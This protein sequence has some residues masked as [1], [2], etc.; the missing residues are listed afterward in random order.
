MLNLKETLNLSMF[1]FLVKTSLLI[2]KP[3][4]STESVER[5]LQAAH[6]KFPGAIKLGFKMSAS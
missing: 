6:I 3:R 4:N 1:W 2:Y 5:E